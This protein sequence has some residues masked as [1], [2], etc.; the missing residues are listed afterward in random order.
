[1]PY[2]A[3]KNP[4]GSVNEFWNLHDGPTTVGRGTES[5]AKV[6]DGVLSRQHFTITK[7][8][9][10]FILKDLGSKNG[11]RVNGQPVTGEVKLKPND[12]IRAGQSQFNFLE[13]L[14]T[15]SMK[16]E[17]DLKDLD[18]IAHPPGSPPAA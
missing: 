2:L 13:G 3:L 6:D 9:G 14:T 11:T 18:R 4:D 1:M 12:E 17:Q 7:T 16:I 8:P 5:N 15:M 10:G